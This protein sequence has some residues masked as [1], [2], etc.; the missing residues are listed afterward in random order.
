MMVVRKGD[1]VILAEGKTEKSFVVLGF[2]KS[3][4]KLA[5]KKNYE[6]SVSQNGEYCTMRYGYKAF[7][8]QSSG[9]QTGFWKLLK[10]VNGTQVS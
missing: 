1:N 10:C 5:D 7:P 2:T 4:A 3:H 9:I 8:L 6:H